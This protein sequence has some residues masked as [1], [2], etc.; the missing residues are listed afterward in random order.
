MKGKQPAL[1]ISSVSGEASIITSTNTT[2]LAAHVAPAVAAMQQP[3]TSEQSFW[4]KCLACCSTTEQK[5]QPVLT[6]LEQFFMMLLSATIASKIQG[7]SNI[8]A[9]TKSA[10]T[11]AAITSVQNLGT[12]ALNGANNASEAIAA[13]DGHILVAIQN[14]GGVSALGQSALGGAMDATASVAQVG[15]NIASAA[16][17]A[18]AT[19]LINSMP[20]LNQQQKI[21]AIAAVSESTG[22]AHQEALNAFG[23][24]EAAAVTHTLSAL[25]HADVVKAISSAASQIAQPTASTGLVIAAQMG[26]NQVDKDIAANISNSTI[27]DSMEASANQGI[28]LTATNLSKAFGLAPVAGSSSAGTAAVTE[29]APLLGESCDVID[30][31]LHCA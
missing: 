1:V 19:D 20:L 3:A 6:E 22:T 18:K 23:T 12:S 21:A 30:A 17:Q 26:Q 7:I 9:E 24:I 29:L 27:A 5:A 25:N 14:A 10:L 15:S 2:L 4:S 28:Q 13:A 31:T 16:V 11:A 8:S